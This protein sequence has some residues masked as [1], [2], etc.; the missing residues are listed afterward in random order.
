VTNEETDWLSKARRGDHHAYGH[1]VRMHQGRLYVMVKRL[2]HSDEDTADVCQDAFVNAYTNLANYRGDSAFF[3]WLY[4]I[5]FNLSVSLLRSKKPVVSLEG[6]SS[7]EYRFEAED[8]KQ[9]P[10]S[11]RMD[12][13]EDVDLL[14]RGLGMLSVEHREILCLKEMDEKPYEEIALLLKIPIGT[15]RSRL[16]RAR[17]ELKQTLL[18]LSRTE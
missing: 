14:R 1:L 3:T 5:A 17:E 16:S 15:V 8:S 4:R 10:P 12:R 18:R 11:E 6:L 7:E 13:G 9:S 2:L